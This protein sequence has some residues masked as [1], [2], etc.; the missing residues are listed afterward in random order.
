MTATDIA[1]IAGVLI[2][3]YKAFTMTPREG[4]VADANAMAQMENVV[5]SSLE[6]SFKLNERV[7]ALEANEIVLK[8]QVRD[9]DCIIEN[10]QKEIDELK[11]QVEMLTHQLQSLNEIPVTVRK[12][13]KD[14]TQK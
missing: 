8:K 5:N 7:L 10:M 6:R 14:S 13:G 2:L 4:N 9:K 12:K 1:T 3:L 11:T